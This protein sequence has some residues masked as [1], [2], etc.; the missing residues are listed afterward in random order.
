[1]ENNYVRIALL[2]AALLTSGINNASAKDKEK[3]KEKKAVEQTV[4]D[5]IINGTN[6]SATFTVNSENLVGNEITLTAPN[7]FTVSPQVIPANS[8]N[9]K[10]TVTLQSYKAVTEGQIILRSEDMR[11]YVSVKGNGS[12]L[13]AKDLSEG[14]TA[15]NP[16]K[17][18][19]SFIPGNDGFTMEFK[20]NAANMVQAFYPYFVDD[21][22]N[23]IKAYV[24]SDGFGLFNG[25]GKKGISNPF[26][27][28]KEG[29]RGRFYN[30]DGQAHTYRIAVTPDNRAFIYRDGMPVDTVRLADYGLQPNFASGIGTVKSNLIKNGDFEGE[31]EMEEESKIAKA[32]EGW[33]ITIGDRWNSEQYITPEELNKS[34]DFNNHAFQIKP[35][36]WRNGWSDA[37]LTQIIDVVPGQTYKLSAL[38]KGGTSTK[39]KKNTGRMIIREVQNEKNCIETEITSDEWNTYTTDFTPSTNCRQVEVIFRVGK[40]SWGGDITPVKVDNVTLSGVSRTYLPIY[41]Y[42]STAELEYFIFDESGAY[43]PLPA[44]IDIVIK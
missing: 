7:G 25:G 26:T 24:T 11:Q 19:Q 16:M 21:K 13:P 22:G 35:Y 1:M 20:V 5:L 42:T 27:Q 14:V 2:S 29:G 15:L 43:A 39:L 44:S 40:G 34:A 28:G 31:Y 8:D 12:A 36:K 30:D 33:N 18:E 32:I 4:P 3:D 10:V 17:M 9:Q 37:S 23:G 6:Q 38:V 41:G